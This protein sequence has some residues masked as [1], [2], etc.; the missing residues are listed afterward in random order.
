MMPWVIVSLAACIMCPYLIANADLLSKMPPSTGLRCLGLTNL[1][2]LLPLKSK[3]DILFRGFKQIIS[4]SDIDFMFCTTY[5]PPKREC[6]ECRI[7][8]TKLE[9]KLLSKD[10]TCGTF[11]T[12]FKPLLLI[13]FNNSLMWHCRSNNLICTRF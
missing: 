13:S 12:F 3:L 1:D 7:T 10:Q 8:F 5:V 4:F 6:L 2:F 11:F 9:N